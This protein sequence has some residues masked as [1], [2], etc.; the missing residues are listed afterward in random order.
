M[1]AYAGNNFTGTSQGFNEGGHDVGRLID[2]PNDTMSS[3]KVSPGYVARLFHESGFWGLP[4]D[5]AGDVAD[6][7]SPLNNNVSSLIVYRGVTMYRE[8]DFQGINQTFM[9]GSFDAE[10]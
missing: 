3:I 2:V 8:V 6:I 7:G 4:Q 9:D 5:Y 1:V 10:A